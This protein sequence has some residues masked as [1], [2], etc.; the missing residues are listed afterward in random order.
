M[1]GTLGG[2]DGWFTNPASQVSAHV[3]IGLDGTVH[4]YV[5]PTDSA[6]A[7]GVLEAGNR[8]PGPAGVNPNLVS[9]SAE[10]EDDGIPENKPVTDAQFLATAAW[11]RAMIELFPS[12]KYL[13]A[14]AAISPKS[15]TCPGARWLNTGRFDALGEF[16]GLTVVR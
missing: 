12:I 6:W 9:I 11:G 2:T 15:R 1:D 14:H 13:V 4:E 3:G 7:N 10:T 16:L 8:W 5:L